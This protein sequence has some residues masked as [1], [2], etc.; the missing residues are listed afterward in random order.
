MVKFQDAEHQFIVTILKWIAGGV[1]SL[2][3]TM[4]MLVIY[5]YKADLHQINQKIDY[6]V[7]TLDRKMDLAEIKI[8]HLEKM[9]YDH[10]NDEEA[11]AH[12][13]I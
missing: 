7:L 12:D 8:D 6:A 2:V 3:V 5:A 10:K 13:R 9:C 1:G 4:G 11:H